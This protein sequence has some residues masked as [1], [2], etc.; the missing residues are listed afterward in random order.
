MSYKY[1]W[2]IER[3]FANAKAMLTF[4]AMNVRKM[5]NNLLIMRIQRE[6]PKGLRMF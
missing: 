4:A 1:V 5:A 3:V 6:F 2:V